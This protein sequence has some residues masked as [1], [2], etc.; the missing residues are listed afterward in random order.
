MKNMKYIKKFELLQENNKNTEIDKEWAYC[1]MESNIECIEE[2][3]QNGYDINKN[4]YFYDENDI[5]FFLRTTALNFAIH[6]YSS[7]VIDILIKYNVDFSS[8]NSNDNTPLMIVSRE[9]EDYNFYDY[10]FMFKKIIEH[11]PKKKLL[12]KNKFGKTF[13]DYLSANKELLGVFI[14]DYPDL[15]RKYSKMKKRKQSIKKF[16]NFFKYKK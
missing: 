15:Y 4:I 11:T 8:P 2:M 14:K 7:D 12:Y 3:I 9:A 6:D 1:I 13:I 16:T 5:P 10:G